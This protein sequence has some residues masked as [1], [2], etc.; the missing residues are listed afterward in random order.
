M[1]ELRRKLPRYHW[2]P[3]VGIRA[4][5]ALADLQRIALSYGI[6]LPTSFALVGKTLAQAD[7]IARALDPAA[8]PDRADRGGRARGDA[9]RG[10]A[11][12]RARAA[13][14]RMATRR[15]SRCCGCR[16]A[17]ASIVQRLE[18]GTLKVG[19]EPT[20]LDELE[21]VAALG[22]EPDRRGVDRRRPADRVGADGARER[23][24]AAL[25]ASRSPAALGLYMLW[26]IIRTPGEL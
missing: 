22:G 23:T 26:K 25:A 8:R 19:I 2:R 6:R 1:H 15:S 16:A 17:S 12:A 21:H 24:I 7:S 5:E 9:A 14:S 11:P 20:G 18:N 3:L 13:C 10:R 4:G